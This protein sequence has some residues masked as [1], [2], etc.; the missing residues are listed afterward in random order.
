MGKQERTMPICLTPEE[1]TLLELYARKKGM[2]NA[3]Q[4]I[5]ELL[6]K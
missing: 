6:A 3:A 5:E 4:A 2:L 1:H